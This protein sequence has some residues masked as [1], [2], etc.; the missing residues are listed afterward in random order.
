MQDF[1]R[2]FLPVGV[3]LGMVLVLLGR[4]L[5]GRTH[6]LATA[7]LSHVHPWHSPTPGP[8]NVLQFDGVAQFVPWRHEVVRQLERGLIPVA[9]PH[10]FSTTGGAP[11]L[12]NSQSAPFYPPNW[13]F[14]LLG[15]QNI[16]YG[17]GLT[18]ALHLLLLASGMIALLV[19]LGA[20]RPAATLAALAS[21]FNVH[22]LAWTAI[23]T[24]LAVLSWSP[25]ILLALHRGL[26][27]R[28]GALMG[29]AILAGHLQIASYVLALVVGA[30]LWISHGL[31]WK[32]RVGRLGQLLTIATLVAAVQWLPAV[33]LS[34]QSHRG[35]VEA[36]AFGY[37]AYLANAIPLHLG[38]TT[39]VPDT[40]GHPS[41]GN[42][43]NWIV[44]TVGQ[45][46]AYAEWA[47]Y[48][49]LASLFLA[50]VGFWVFLR[51]GRSSWIGSCGWSPVFVCVALLVAFG[52]PLTRALY[53]GIPGF[54]ATGNP[55]RI[56][57]I[58]C[59]P[60][61][62][63]AAVALDHLNWKRLSLS[64][65]CV[66]V[67]GIACQWNAS[68]V[69]VAL[70]IDSGWAQTLALPSLLGACA[71]AVLTLAALAYL[72]QKPRLESAK[73][74]VVM[75]L[76]VDLAISAAGNIPEGPKDVLLRQPEG[77][78]WLG[79]NAGNAPVAFLNQKW[80]MS[81][82]GPARFNPVLP[83]NLS[84]YWGIKDVGGY[85]SMILRRTK[86]AIREAHGG[87]EPSPPENGNM[88]FVRTF[89]AA[90]RLGA[91]FAASSPSLPAPSP[92]AWQ[93]EYEGDDLRIYR[94][95]GSPVRISEPIEWLTTAVRTGL[96]LFLVAAGGAVAR[97]VSRR[98]L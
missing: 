76:A 72:A 30:E 1:L 6:M 43:A 62:I 38:L 35:G 53:F 20:S 12:A 34:R 90:A 11:L 85:D 73:W 69:M 4:P 5:S 36:T 77:L 66:L 37:Q 16:G 83:P 25:W 18:T 82:E 46:N 44:N 74:L 27:F 52:S 58:V 54:A 67:F 10:A 59:I 75:V 48:F 68:R 81:A 51:K 95:I 91:A 89:D 24:H 49:G 32:T 78:R 84:G 55:G 56:W 8:W 93:V 26:P 33:E 15:R 65:F 40:F 61:G 29:M 13:I 96:F 17:F 7:Q 41:K 71:F 42:G 80:S 3:V 22:L 19:H 28:A 21:S 23:P 98:S 94:Y 45:P 47:L 87:V 9:N 50:P 57:A 2:R 60:L 31:P 14:S 86:D 88:V 70:G 39:L 79:R 97:I 63:M 92:D 64:L